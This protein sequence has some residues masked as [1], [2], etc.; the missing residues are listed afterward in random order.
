TLLSHWSDKLQQ[1]NQALRNTCAAA[2][3]L[4]SIVTDGPA[5]DEN[6]T[7]KGM[8]DTFDGFWSDSMEAFNKG[9]A[10]ARENNLWPK[11][12]SWGKRSDRQNITSDKAKAEN[13]AANDPRKG[14]L[15]SKA[16]TN[17]K[18]YKRVGDVLNNK[19]FEREIKELISNIGGTQINDQFTKESSSPQANNK[20]STD[21]SIPCEGNNIDVFT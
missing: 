10:Q 9:K 8:M 4:V 2:N 21:T 17:S 16:L 14:N 5:Q 18:S 15:T 6:K 7:R 13:E 20:C 1:M 12:A 19:G 11:L 3:K